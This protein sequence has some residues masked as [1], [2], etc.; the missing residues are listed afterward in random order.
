MINNLN[1]FNR[2]LGEIMMYSQ[3]IEHDIKEIYASILG[4][5]KEQNYE[6]I[7]MMTLGEA[8]LNMQELD[9]RRK[10]GLFSIDEYLDLKQITKI[11]N[12]WAHSAYN[13]F[14]Y[15]DDE[16][17]YKL[18]CKRLEKDI[19]KLSYIQN[20]IEEKKVKLENEKYGKN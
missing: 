3:F 20:Y 14:A 13:D 18:T 7:K 17:Y 5:P 12:Y 19:A 11:R 9:I 1:D 2:N 15:N 8:I 4:G 6:N 16:T 10:M